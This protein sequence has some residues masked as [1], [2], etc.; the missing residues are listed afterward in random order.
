MAQSFVAASSQYLDG[1]WGGTVEPL[2]LACW[3]NVAN[4][5]TGYTL[6]DIADRSVSYRYFSLRARGDLAGDHV[7]LSVNDT[8][9]DDVYTTTSYS[10]NTWHHACGVMAA[11]DDRRVYLD[12]GGKATSAA[13]ISPGPAVNTVTLARSG[14]S[15]PYGLLDGLLAEVSIW[16]VAL[17]DVEVQVL[18]RGFSPLLV[19]PQGLIRYW[20]LIRDPGSI[21]VVRGLGLT[22]YNAPTVGDHPPIIYPYGYVTPGRVGAAPATLRTL[23]TLGAGR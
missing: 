10:A 3:F 20:R 12:A 8:T 5:T 15:T 6:L 19:R 7:G 14:D 16:N 18:A 17:T 21:E 4:I 13:S 22:A 1:F 11:T 2:T 9:P 23:A